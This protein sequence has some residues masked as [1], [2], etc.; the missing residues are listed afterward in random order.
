[1]GTRASGRIAGEAGLGAGEPVGCWKGCGGTNNT[2]GVCV[3]TYTWAAGVAAL[4]SQ[5]AVFTTSH[6][7]T[8][9]PLFA[10]KQAVTID[11]SSGGRF[12]LN[13]LCGRYGAERLMFSGHMMGHG[14]RY[15]YAEEWQAI[16]KNELAQQTPSDLKGAYSHICGAIPQ[17][18]PPQKPTQTHACASPGAP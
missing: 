9:H 18:Q 15:A 2:G 14:K 11:H 4:T 5:I 12:G 8:G 7:P 1:A 17:P 6:L 13:I 16:A 3:E 10:A